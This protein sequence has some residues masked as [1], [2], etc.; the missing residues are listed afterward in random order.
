[1]KTIEVTVDPNG[2][3]KVE[4]KGFA[5]PEC[6]AASRSLE[7]ALGVRSNEHL[8]PEFYQNQRLDEDLK[9]SQ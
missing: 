4:T 1:M 9:Q 7:Q 8:T 6:R 5:G 2:Q 3:T